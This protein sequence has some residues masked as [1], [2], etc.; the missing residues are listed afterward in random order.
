VPEDTAEISES[1]FE[2]PTI[3]DAPQEIEETLPEEDT[4]PMPDWLKGFTQEPESTDW[5]PSDEATQKGAKEPAQD[6]G[7]IPEFKPE[8]PTTQASKEQYIRKVT[9]PLRPDPKNV[10]SN[11]N[12]ALK[13]YD[14]DTALESYTQLIERGELLDEVIFDLREALYRYPIDVSI[15]QALGDAYIRNN[16]LQEALDAYTKAEELLR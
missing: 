13:A 4:E 3:P 12:E 2:E 16:Q 6:S 14:I 5:A 11:A 15:W 10:L 8:P 7:W 9:G 1:S